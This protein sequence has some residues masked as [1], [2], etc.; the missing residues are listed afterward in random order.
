MT[1]LAPVGDVVAPVINLPPIEPSREP[2]YIRNGD[3]AAKKAYATALGFE[4]ILVNQLAQQLTATMSDPGDSSD[5]PSS[6]PS[7]SGSGGS[8]S[9]PAGGAYSQ[10]LPGALT[11]SIM[12]SGGLGIASQ[13]AAGLDPA[14]RGRR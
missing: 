7:S 6:D 11:A 13:I 10:M 3:A 9:D 8:G 1:A 14:L 5:G 4:Q 12:S 2:A